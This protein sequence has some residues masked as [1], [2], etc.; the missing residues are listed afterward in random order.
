MGKQVLLDVA[1]KV[2]MLHAL[3]GGASL[4]VPDDECDGAWMMIPIEGITCN[5]DLYLALNLLGYYAD[6][7]ED[8]RYLGDYMLVKCFQYDDEESIA[9]Q[10]TPQRGECR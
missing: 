7:Y 2:K 3:P 1:S 4:L 9:I 5:T 8:V 6:H 10:D